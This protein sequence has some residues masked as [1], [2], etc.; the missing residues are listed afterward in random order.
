MAEYL[1]PSLGSCAASHGGS[2][3][4][5]A[6]PENF[7]RSPD[8]PNAV[9]DSVTKKTQKHKWKLAWLR[10]VLKMPV[11]VLCALR[12]S[13]ERG[14][15]QCAGSH[16][17][18]VGGYSMGAYPGIPRTYSTRSQSSEDDQREL[19]RAVSQSMLAT[20]VIPAS[21]GPDGM[22]RS[23]SAV[24]GRIDEDKE[25]DFADGSPFAIGKPF[26]RSRSYAVGP[27]SIRRVGAPA[28]DVV[29]RRA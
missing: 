25:A 13:Y 16:A 24:V 21:V 15:T 6:P 4:T 17:A 26:P 2:T 29:F 22:Q 9:T 12:D 3:A 1:Y 14:M 19:V 8:K 20:R 23:R 18:M 28:V 7:P 5:E 27:S 10:A 11:R